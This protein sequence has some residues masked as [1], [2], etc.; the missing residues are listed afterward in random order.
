[1]KGVKVNG[2]KAQVTKDH[3]RPSEAAMHH[4]ALQ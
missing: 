1:M 4:W 3:T 2:E